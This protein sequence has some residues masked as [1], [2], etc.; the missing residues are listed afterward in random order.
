M[1]FRLV[2]EVAMTT[3]QKSLG[4]RCAQAFIT[5]HHLNFRCRNVASLVAI[6]V[7]IERDDE[8]ARVIA[9]LG[10]IILKQRIE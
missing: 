5:S 4:T 10:D 9:V 3:P 8:G 2:H 1:R 6:L 7:A